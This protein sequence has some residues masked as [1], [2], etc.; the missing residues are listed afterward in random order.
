MNMPAARTVAFRS[1]ERNVFFH[2]LTACNLACSHCYINRDQHGT[3]MLSWKK[4]EAW[5][6]LFVRPG[7]KA[8]IVF[9][10]GEPTLHPDVVGIVESIQMRGLTSSRDQVGMYYFPMSQ[11]VRRSLDR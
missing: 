8:N 9:L 4:L 6:K 3:Q 7:R 2:I 1:E 10:G 5:I 11:S